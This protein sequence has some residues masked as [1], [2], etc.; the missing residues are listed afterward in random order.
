MTLRTSAPS[1]LNTEFSLI[2]DLMCAS[3]GIAFPNVLFL[4]LPFLFYLGGRE[5]EIEYD[6]LLWYTLRALHQRVFSHQDG[7]L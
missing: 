5:R 4:L 6:H 7:G 3:S 2:S 1:R